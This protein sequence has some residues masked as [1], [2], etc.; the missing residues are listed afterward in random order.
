M[1]RAMYSGITGLK[2]FQ[3]Q[4]DVVGNNIAN[5]NTVG[6]KSSRVTFQTTLLQTLKSGKSPDGQFGG[7]NPMQIGMGSKV[8]S[9]DK[10]MSQ[11]SFQNTGKITD[12]AIQGD[13]FFVL[14]DG[15]GSYFTRAGNFT[16]DT[17][18]YLVD[19]SSGMKLQGWTAKISSSGKRYVDSNDP[20]GDIQISAGQVMA[21]KQ[22]TF[23]NLAHNLKSDVGI[24]ESTIVIK[25]LSGQNI[26]VKFR[27]ER[28]MSK[29]NRDKIVYKW[30]AES[31]NE[32]YPLKDNK[33]YLELDE[34]GNVKEWI[35]YDGN[36]TTPKSDPKI[37][38]GIIEKY[39]IEQTGTPPAYPTLSIGNGASTA[40]IEGDII[41][42]KDGKSVEIDT[43]PTKLINVDFTAGTPG[44]FKVT[45]N[46]KDG[47]SLTF[48]GTGNTVKDINDALNKGLEDA[49][50]GVKLTG[51]QLN[52]T[53]TSLNIDDGTAATLTLKGIERE[54]LQPATGGEIKLTDLETPTN[55]S[56]VKYQ[57]PTVSTS[58]LIFDSLGNSYNAYIKFTKIDENT[59]QWKAQLEDGTPLKK[60]DQQGNQTDE[61]AQGVIAFDSNGS[62]A[63]T[64][65]SIEDDGSINEVDGKGGFGF[66]FDPAKTGGALDQSQEPSS[67]SAAGPVKVEIK[68][69][70]ITQF[71]SPNSVTVNDQDG[72][73]EGTLESFAINEVGEVVGS[74]SNGRS[75]IL[76]RVALATF[77][78]PE[79]LME[80]G[81]SLYAQSS[82]SG[83]AQIGIA[84]VGGRGTLIPGALEMSNVDLAEEFTNM[85]VAQRGFQATSRII[86]TSDQ[87]LNELVNMKR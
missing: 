17:S 70:N 20:I 42:T 6:F 58:T 56:K 36:T 66:W 41:L 87:I 77:N 68:F 62:I 81:N 47:T 9:V 50:N 76:G 79:G 74:F 18:G 84:G 34:S 55:F 59:W 86:T 37:R 8:A 67:S 43:T 1:L 71:A 83:L 3:T 32:D 80:I 4:M 25:S 21:A 24:K 45:L 33:G 29:A 11:S 63:A 73:A 46:D 35:T 57:S 31:L 49:A 13:G 30:T 38:L 72:N 52:A 61:I 53:D 23:V 54:V 14:S 27:F 48:I 28:D 5:V 78:N 16:R 40:S 82:N 7:T 39:N 22:T 64:D 2:N 51:L 10:I 85:I 26:P 69:N 19:P 44:T 12:L 75:D 15:E 60:L 65:W